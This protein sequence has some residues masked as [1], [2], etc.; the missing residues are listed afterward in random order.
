[1]NRAGLGA[2]GMRF[3]LLFQRFTFEHVRG[4][5]VAISA[6]RT[7]V[8]SATIQLHFQRVAS[9]F[10]RIRRHVTQDIELILF[11]SDAFESGEEIVGVENREAARSFRKSGE[12]LL[13]G[14]SRRRKLRNNRPWLAVGRIVVIGIGIKT[15]AAGASAGSTACS[16]TRAASATGSAFTAASASCATTTRATA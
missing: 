3:E 4:L 8:H 1:M 2:R 7:H 12:D 14:R 15:P 6:A 16:S 5:R 11:T 13:V 9:P 10:G